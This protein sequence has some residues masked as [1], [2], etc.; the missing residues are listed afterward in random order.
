MSEIGRIFEVHDEFGNV[1]RIRILQCNTGFGIFATRG[2]PESSVIG[3]ITGQINALPHGTNY[4]FDLEDGRQL[5]PD[6]PFRFVNHSCDPNCEFDWIEET[7]SNDQLQVRLYL[8]ALRPIEANEQF[9]IDY[10]W[11]ASYAIQCDCR[12]PLCRGWVVAEEELD[13]LWIKHQLGQD[14]REYDDDE[15]AGSA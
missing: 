7:D 2:Y 8:I 10:N 14:E 15:L 5:E 9:T 3:E 4:S 13:K 6:E 11:P 12:S 1:D